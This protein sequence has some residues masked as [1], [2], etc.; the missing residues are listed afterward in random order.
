VPNLGPGLHS[1]S[2]LGVGIS[3]GDSPPTAE[4]PAEPNPN[5]LLWSEEMQQAVWTVGAGTVLVTADGGLNP[6]GDE[7]TADLLAFGGTGSVIGQT[8]ATAAAT[9]AAALSTLSLTGGYSR[10]SLSGTFDGVVY[11]LSVN[12]QEPLGGG[13]ELQLR[14]ERSGGFL[15][16]G[17]RD[18]GDSPTVLAWG[19]K[20]ETPD[21]TAYVKR[22]G[23]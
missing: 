18:L 13:S 22:E 16:G 11:F 10:H 20:L 23:S 12:L 15:R 5:L 6:T 1:G 7:T 17:L 14:L 3:P 2:A 19:W 4:A 9:G 8:S 21:L